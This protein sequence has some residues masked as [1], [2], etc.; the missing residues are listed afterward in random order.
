MAAKN[1]CDTDTDET[2]EELR[3][4]AD[5]FQSI[6]DNSALGIFQSS[7]EGRFLRV[8]PAFAE[9]LG[10]ESPEDLIASIE[11]IHNQ[12]Y[13]APERRQEIMAAVEAEDDLS[14]FEAELQRKDGGVITA[15]LNIR[16]VRDRN[17]KVT[18]L[19]GFIE[20]VT[21]ARSREREIKEQAERLTRENRR[22]SIA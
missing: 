21:V 3:A 13:A 1:S 16:A 20:D 5:E 22:I 10:Y 14:R 18:H 8:N 17:G 19:D 15:S 9:I 12:F 11:D 2:V 6:F 4:R 7:V